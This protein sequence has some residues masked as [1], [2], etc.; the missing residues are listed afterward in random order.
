[1]SYTMDFARTSTSAQTSLHPNVLLR[2]GVANAVKRHS[3]CF[4]W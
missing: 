3:M 1:M 4:I 2:Q